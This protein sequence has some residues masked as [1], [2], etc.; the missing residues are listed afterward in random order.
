VQAAFT[1]TDGGVERGEAAEAD[2]E[3][4]DGGARSQFAV[5]VLEDGD[6]RGGGVGSFFAWL[7]GSGAW[8]WGL[9]ANFEDCWVVREESRGWGGRRGKDLQELLQG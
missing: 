7:S 3:R 6:E 4:G 9:W 5:L 1:E 2:V 8:L